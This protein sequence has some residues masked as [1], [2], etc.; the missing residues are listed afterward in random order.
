MAGTIVDLGY[1]LS[2]REVV[3]ASEDS[4]ELAARANSDVIVMAQRA[5]TRGFVCAWIGDSVLAK[6]RLEPLS[7]L[8]AVDG[9]TDALDLGPA[10]YLPLLRDPV[11]VAHQTATVDQVSVVGSISELASASVPT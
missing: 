9:A 1:L 2:T 10:V 11:H 6:P 8:A 4:P 7:T 3:L 5:E